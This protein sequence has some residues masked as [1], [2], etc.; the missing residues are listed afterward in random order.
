MPTP[1]VVSRSPFLPR[2]AH[3]PYSHVQNSTRAVLDQLGLTA[4]RAMVD[5]EPYGSSDFGGDPSHLEPPSLTSASPSED[6][7][8]EDPENPIG[9]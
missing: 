2:M 8:P 7:D 1:V 9:I 4:L 5:V 6:D 3:P